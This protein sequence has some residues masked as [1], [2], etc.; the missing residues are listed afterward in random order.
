M[1]T[2]LLATA[3]FI[4]I[5]MACL[6]QKHVIPE[7]SDFHLF[8]VEHLIPALLGLDVIP[9]VS[10]AAEHLSSTGLVCLAKV[11]TQG[12]CVCVTGLSELEV[13]AVVL[14]G[15]SFVFLDLV[16][17]LVGHVDLRCVVLQAPAGQNFNTTFVDPAGGGH[18]VLF[19]QL[20]R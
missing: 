19:Q 20:K 11:A 17:A 14:A 5:T 6:R 10:Q 18:P 2:W 16:L 13:E 15:A 3:I 4:D 12:F 8:E 7:V 1:H 9:L